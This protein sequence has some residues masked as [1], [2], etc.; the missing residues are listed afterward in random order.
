MTLILPTVGC[1]DIKQNKT[2]QK[3][4]CLPKAH[5]DISDLTVLDGSQR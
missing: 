3:I 4:S 2:K 5:K 1:I